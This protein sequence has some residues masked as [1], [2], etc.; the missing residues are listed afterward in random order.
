[1]RVKSIDK[2]KN[3]NNTQE[4][5]PSSRLKQSKPYHHPLHIINPNNLSLNLVIPLSTPHTCAFEFKKKKERRIVVV[6]YYRNNMFDRSLWR[7][8]CNFRILLLLV[9]ISYLVVIYHK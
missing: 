2:E 6:L 3:K 8:F 7:Y 4:H 1:M 9:N 5:T